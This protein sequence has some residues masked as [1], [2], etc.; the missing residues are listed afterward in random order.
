MFIYFS[1]IIYILSMKKIFLL[2]GNAQGL[3]PSCQSGT[4]VA[5][6]VGSQSRALSQYDETIGPQ[7]AQQ[8]TQQQDDGIIRHTRGNNNITFFKS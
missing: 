6:S 7:G 1:Y 8:P 3:S 2:G 5:A 4:H